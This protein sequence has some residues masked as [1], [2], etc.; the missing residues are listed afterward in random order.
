VSRDVAA[1][2]YREIEQVALDA[3]HA[4]GCADWS[5]WTCGRSLWRPNVIELNPL[6]GIIPD[7]R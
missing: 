4:I 2:L 7:P 1:P 6:P 5:V 3:Y